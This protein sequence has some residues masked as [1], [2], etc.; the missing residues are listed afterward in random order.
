MGMTSARLRVQAEYRDLMIA[1][2]QTVEGWNDPVS[3][4]FKARRLDPLDAPLRSLVTAIEKAEVD[5][6]KAKRDCQDD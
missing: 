3:Q 6:A 2:N 5:I 1:W 4:A